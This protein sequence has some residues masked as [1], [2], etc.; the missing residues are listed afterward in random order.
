[1]TISDYLWSLVAVSIK[2]HRKSLNIDRRREF[3]NQ[4]SGNNEFDSIKNSGVNDVLIDDV[5]LNMIYSFHNWFSQLN[6][7]D[8]FN[9]LFFS[10]MQVWGIQVEEMFVDKEICPTNLHALIFFIVLYLYQFN[11][12][13]WVLMSPLPTPY[14]LLIIFNKSITPDV[15]RPFS[16]AIDGIY[17]FYLW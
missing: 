4:I 1:M 10:V 12:R 15:S 16:L 6:I 11:V 9:K 2:G 7:I 14:L 17:L 3:G 13:I 5:R 8:W